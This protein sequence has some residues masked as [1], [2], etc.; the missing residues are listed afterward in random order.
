[1][2][3]VRLDPDLGKEVAER[4]GREIT[5][6]Y[7]QRILARAKTLADSRAK[8]SSVAGRIDIT[9]RAN[10]AQGWRVAMAVTGRDGS[11]IAAHLEFGYFNIW[12]QHRLPGMHIMRDA[13]LGG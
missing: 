2:A 3:Y 1:M 13:A 7:A 10:H 8:H 12:A 11:L 6:P 9:V 5:R 4:Y